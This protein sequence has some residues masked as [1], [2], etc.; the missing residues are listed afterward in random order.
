MKIRRASKPARSSSALHHERTRGHYVQRFR[1]IAGK[2][3]GLI[4][5]RPGT[6]YYY[7]LAGSSLKCKIISPLSPFRN[8][9]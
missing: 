2:P 3:T 8:V 1:S 6:F 9:P 7:E 4:K 5:E